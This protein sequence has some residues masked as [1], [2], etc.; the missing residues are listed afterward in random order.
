MQ[1][2]IAISKPQKAKEEGL[3][4]HQ[5]SMQNVQSNFSHVLLLV[6]ASSMCQIL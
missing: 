3:E 4:K 2:Q 6:I 5:E 1:G